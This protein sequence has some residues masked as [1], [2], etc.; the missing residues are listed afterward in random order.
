MLATLLLLSGGI[1]TALSVVEICLHK[2]TSTIPYKYH[3]YNRIVVACSCGQPVDMYAYARERVCE[4]M[5]SSLQSGHE[6]EPVSIVCLHTD[7]CLN[8]H[9]DKASV[10]AQTLLTC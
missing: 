10:F 8:Y 6:R 1:A 5:L 9:L 4:S 3:G 7:T 2:I